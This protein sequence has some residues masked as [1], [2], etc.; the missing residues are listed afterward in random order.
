MNRSL[1][2][3]PDG[4]PEPL[5]RA[6]IQDRAVRGAMWTIVHTLIALPTAFLVNLVVAN[7]LQAA[8]YGRLAVLTAIMEVA[9]GVVALGLAPAV[10]QFGTKAHT[11]G[12]RGE[13]RRLLSAAQGFRLM[14]AAPLLTVVV[15]TIAD[16]SPSFLALAVA[17]GV[18]L[19]AALSG[20]NICLTLEH[21]TAEAARVAMV[22][23]VVVQLTVLVVVLTMRTPDSVWAARLVVSGLLMGLSLF[24]I[25]PDYRAAVLRPRLPRRFPPGFWKF[26]IPAGISGLVATLVLSR[27]EVFFLTALAT[28]T[29]AGLFAL[30][31]GVA[32]HAFAPAQALIGPLV[33]A[34]SGLREVDRASVHEGFVR[35]V[36]TTSTVVG[37]LVALALA[38]LAVLVPV[39]YGSS[40]TA[41]APLVLVLGISG[42]LV[43]ATGPISV[44]VLARYSARETLVANL[45]AL[46]VDVGLAIALIPSLGAW[47]AVI[48]N[49][50]GA[51]TRFT[52]LLR[53]ERADLQIPWHRVLP[54][55]GALPVAALSCGL[56]WGAAML[57][58]GGTAA[59]TAG[60]GAHTILAACVAAVVSLTSFVAGV[61]LT[62][63]GL[64]VPEVD[65]I[66]RVVPG[67]AGAAIGATLRATVQSNRH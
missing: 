50:A 30:A 24:W 63:T 56:G 54:L 20:A 21:K 23:N 59:V 26:A 32:S 46:A 43:V 35:A 34:V 48:A 28:P 31:F 66:T 37:S 7:V 44:F 16:V 60:S 17:F 15:V 41:A 18:W 22:G 4:E 36:R 10:V 3:D 52:V 8:N 39:L 9:G 51:L 61:R 49:V 19:P 27:T 33:P 2:P 12:A 13:V 57:L 11:R 40:F 62:G 6:E 1:P 25:S 58:P 38:P 65:A 67:R 5:S 47:G 14:V 42:A 53:V 45:V 64:S 55:L 29:A